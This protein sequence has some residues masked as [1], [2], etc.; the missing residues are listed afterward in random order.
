MRYSKGQVRPQHRLSCAKI[1]A[2]VSLVGVI[3]NHPE[4]ATI[5]ADMC[6]DNCVE[7]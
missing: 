5:L 6:N 4:Y 1:R 2:E 7:V 3:E